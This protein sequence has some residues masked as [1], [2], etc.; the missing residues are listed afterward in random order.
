MAYSS[1]EKH[2]DAVD[3]F[4]KALELEPSNESYKTNLQLAEEKVRTA[5]AGMVMFEV[6]GSRG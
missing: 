6:D 3:C 1:V 5:P 4:K 2:K